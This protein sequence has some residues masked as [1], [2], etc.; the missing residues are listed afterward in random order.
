MPALNVKE[1]LVSSL[2]MQHTR[3]V[4]DLKALPNE[5][6]LRSYAGCARTP[7]YMIAE[8]AWVNDWMATFLETGKS[9]RL[10]REEQDALFG[11]VDTAEKALAMLDNSVNRLAAAYEALDENTLG[12]ITDQP[13]GRPTPKFAPASLPIGHMMYHDGQ[14]NYI[15]TL[16]GDDKIH[17]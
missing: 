2:R 11:S 9:D 15:Q 3:L 14:L 8:C 4:N 1:Y 6:H 10:P 7:L 12:D 5:T 13:L 17:W 16:L